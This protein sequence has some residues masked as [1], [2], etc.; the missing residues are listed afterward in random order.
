[1]GDLA[2]GRQAIELD[3]IGTELAEALRRAERAE[4]EGTLARQLLSELRVAPRER[5]GGRR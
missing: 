2:Q 3:R 4:A 1:V 5:S